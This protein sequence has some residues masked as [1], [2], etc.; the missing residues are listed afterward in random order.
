MACHFTISRTHYVHTRA[1]IAG[2]LYVSFEGTAFAV[3]GKWIQF[4]VAWM[5]VN[6]LCGLLGVMWWSRH[7]DAKRYSGKWLSIFGCLITVAMSHIMLSVFMIV[8]FVHK[9]RAVVYSRS[10]L[11]LTKDIT[12]IEKAVAHRC[13]EHSFYTYIHCIYIHINIYIY[14]QCIYV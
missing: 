11:V 3:S 1:M 5:A 10:N 7:R 8:L 14:I 9:L 12:D 6:M 13:R 4:V 2:R